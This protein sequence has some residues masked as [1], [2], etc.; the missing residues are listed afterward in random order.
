M[1]K[2]DSPVKVLTA[3][4]A[5]LVLATPNAFA[6]FCAMDNGAVHAHS[7]AESEPENHRNGN[8][9][10]S[11]SAESHDGHHGDQDGESDSCCQKLIGPGTAL[12]ATTAPSL[13]LPMHTDN[14]ATLPTSPVVIVRISKV[15]DPGFFSQDSGPPFGRPPSS[16]LGR[17]PPVL[18][19]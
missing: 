13:G 6:V 11:N 9:H 17:A 7:K 18:V 5:L 16:N 12:V 15:R 19:A 10:D 4:L 14:P 8:D 3:T 2:W 1:F